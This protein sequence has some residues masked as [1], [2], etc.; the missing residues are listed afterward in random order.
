MEDDKP[1]KSRDRARTEA[2][3][4]AA[5]RDQLAEGGFQG[6]GVN[7]VARRAGCDKQLIYRYFGGLEGLVDAIG[8]ELATWVDDSLS[9]DT[10]LPPQTYRDLMERL[11]LA[12]LDAFRANQLVQK[13]TAWEVAEPSPL[14]ARLAQARAVALG[15]WMARQRA[16]LEPPPGV[17]APAVNAL[18]IAAVQHLVLS[19]TTTGGFAGVSL[20]TEAEW[21]RIRT[22]ILHIIDGFYGTDGHVQS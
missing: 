18:L 1:G 17:D 2:A 10:R 6:F 3:I 5:A 15:A 13:I 16:G 21:G 7:T 9:P 14:A 12:F 8:L 4:L 20:Q 22:A 11:I 19:A